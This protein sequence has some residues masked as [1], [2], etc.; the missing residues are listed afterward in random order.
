MTQPRAQ[1][2]RALQLALGSGLGPITGTL[3]DGQNLGAFVYC[4]ARSLSS[5]AD[6]TITVNMTRTPQGY[7]Q[8]RAPSGGGVITDGASNGSDWTQGKVVL[9]ASVTGTYSFLVF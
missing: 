1:D 8:T 6:T 5:S 3:V 9:R 2:T 7:L 4:K